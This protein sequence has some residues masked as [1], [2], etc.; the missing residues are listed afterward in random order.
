MTPRAPPVLQ[1]NA[2]GDVNGSSLCDCDCPSKPG[3]WLATGRWSNQWW[4]LTVRYLVQQGG[5]AACNRTGRGRGSSSWQWRGGNTE[6]TRALALIPFAQNA[7]QPRLDCWDGGGD[8]GY[9]GG[10][11]WGEWLR[12]VQGLRAASGGFQKLL[13]TSSV[14][15]L[16][17]RYSHF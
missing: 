14:W 3:S 10:A 16:V 4:W 13:V 8:G 2:S 11:M 9:L 12:G 17:T 1:G 15:V 5:R 6:H 7:K